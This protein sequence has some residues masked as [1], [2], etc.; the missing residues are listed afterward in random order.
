MD[1]SSLKKGDK[2]LVATGSRNIGKDRLRS[3]TKKRRCAQVAQIEFENDATVLC[4]PAS[5][6]MKG[7]DPSAPLQS[8]NFTECNGGCL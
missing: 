8:D 4:S 2:V 7:N 6:L 5:I 3:V 1:A